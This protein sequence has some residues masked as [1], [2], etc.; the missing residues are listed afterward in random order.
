MNEACVRCWRQTCWALVLTL[1][2]ATQLMA[3]PPVQFDIDGANRRPIS[4]FIYGSNQP[5]WQ[6][7]ETIYTLARWG[8]NRATTYNWETNASNAGA[9]WHHQNDAYLSMS[10]V[11]GEPV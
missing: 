2:A 11:P 5:N 7:H 10:D 6:R 1:L 8:G 9:D 3:G 4:P